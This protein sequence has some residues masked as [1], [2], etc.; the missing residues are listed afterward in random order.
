MSHGHC[1]FWQPSLVW[2]HVVSDS[3]IAASYFSIP[4]TLYYFI[5]QRPDVKL[6]GVILMFAG[7]ILA[8]GTTHLLSVW[9]IW[10]SAYRLE[11]LL[12]AITATLSVATAFVAMR[13]GP[14]VVKV[15]S[16]EQLEEVNRKLREEIAARDQAEE[17]LRK[18]VEAE[19]LASKG[20][21]QSFFEA[22]PQ[23]IIG[24]SPAGLISMVNRRTEEMFD[25]SRSEL[26]GEPLEV[27]LPE[28]FRANHIGHRNSYFAEP[29]VRPMGAGMDLAGRCKNGRE[30]PI[31][32]GLSHVKT[33]EG[34]LAFGLITDI[35]ER[36][37]AEEELQRANEELR[38]S[39]V[40]IEQF[41]HIAS[42]DLQEPLRMVTNYLQLIERRYA[43]RL[44]DNGREFIAFAVDGAKRMKALIRD[45]LELSRAG[46]YTANFRQVEAS[47][48]LEHALEN[49]K[50]AIEESGAQITTDP[51]PTIVCDPVLLTQ[52]FQNLIG[53]A[54]KFQRDGSPCIH[55][56]ANLQDRGC[57]FSIQDNGIGIESQ[58]IDRIFRI[59]ERLHT[60][61][62]YSGSG[63]GLAITRKI[64]ERHGG[65]IWVDSKPG[66]GSTF[67]FSAF[68]E[69]DSAVIS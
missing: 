44:D 33:P 6:R 1:F 65:K 48:V 34:M 23:G 58:H 7:F 2:L 37:R 49:L 15:A 25:Y 51:L 21:V 19:L 17:K 4:F 35:S 11:G 40:E 61:D 31:E 26:L 69:M 36:K 64:V 10:H 62:Q 29:R 20:I 32:I 9:D 54:I 59:F 42:H 27:L 16:P 38:R 41:A 55:I 47:S 63:I 18:I 46:T 22:A 66:S 28:R 12:K 5:R 43:N 67:Y 14:A 30:F 50:A 8:C 3:L 60:T 56:S 24:V 13:L 57:V 68:A 39:N 53:N 45:L 52:V